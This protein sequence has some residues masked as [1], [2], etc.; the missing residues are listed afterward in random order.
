MYKLA[1]KNIARRR[2]KTM[3]TIALT[4]CMVAVIVSS[5]L[6]YFLISRGL[7]LS[8]KRIGAD[9]L[10][11]P[12]ETVLDEEELLFTGIEQMIY[13]DK[14]V[15]EGK[16][17]PMDVES[18]SGQFFIQTK[19]DA[20]C[21]STGETFR[22]VGVDTATDF[23]LKPW[24]RK[25][26]PDA[27]NGLKMIV[28]NNIQK[29]FGETTFVLNEEFNVSG[30]LYE[31]G[32]G[33]DDSI[34]MNIDMARK[35]GGD[36]FDKKTFGRKNPEDLVSCYLIKLKEGVD[37]EFFADVLKAN[38]VDAK[39]ASVPEIQKEM[40]E[41][42]RQM[43]GILLIFAITVLFLGI[44]AL[45]LHFTNIVNNR[46][47]EIGYLRAIGLNRRDIY[48]MFL[49]EAEL[50]GVIGGVL[51]AL[52][53]LIGMKIVNSS[54]RA[55]SIIPEGSWSNGLSIACF[56]L[57]IVVAVIVCGASILFS[58][59]KVAGSEPSEIIGREGM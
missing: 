13:M 55:I 12:K 44:M 59:R 57:G 37:A 11:Y 8:E 51:G 41:Q 27:L 7:S 18:I 38:E 48:K 23:V 5:F 26:Q 30:V 45:I 4:M 35:I 29:A 58:A 6:L 53:G 3:V 32:T 50:G 42:G 21:C 10:V 24:L 15:L 31:T 9:V 56:A 22:I 49:I 52:I 43:I 16:Y 40:Q 47:F 36:S 2:N 39:V 34:F 54:I 19:P 33:M 14:D 46:K 20:G 17:D 25:N 28:G 1:Y